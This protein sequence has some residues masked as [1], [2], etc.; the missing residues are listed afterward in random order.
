MR[1]PSRLRRRPAVAGVLWMLSFAPLA[2]CGGG[3]GGGGGGGPVTPPASIAYALAPTTFETGDV[4]APVAPQVTGGAPDTFAVAPSLPAGLVLSP[5][6]GMFSGTP[7]TPTPHGVYTVTA[8]NSA[9]S[10]QTTLDLTVVLARAENLAPKD[11]ATF[12]DDD[13]RYFLGRTH[14][15]TKPSEV[16]AVKAVGIPAYVD[17]MVDA[18]GDT[19]A[20][21]EN[22]AAG[23]LVNATDPVGLEGG[24][25]SQTQVARYWMHLMLNNPQPFQDALA[26]FWHDHF[27]SSTTPIESNATWF[28]VQQVNLWRKQGSGNL[29]SLLL[30]MARDSMML[31][32]LDGILNTKSAPNENFAREWFELFSLGVDNG[33]TQTDIVQAA[34]AFTGY[35]LRF[36]ATTGQ[37]FTQFD[38]SRHDTGAKTVLGVTIPG[39]NVTDDYQAVVDATIDHRPVAEFISKKLF[40]YFC[41]QGPTNVPTDAMAALLRNNAY[42]LKPLLKALFKSEAFYAPKSKAG[43]VK[44]PVEHYV[45]FC[46]TTGL[47]PIDNKAITDPAAWPQNLLRTVDTVL[48]TCAQRPSQP[49]SVNGWPVSEEWLSAQNMLDRVNGVRECIRDRTDQLAANGGVDPARALLSAAPTSLEAVDQLA[50]LLNVKLTDPERTQLANYLDTSYNATTGVVTASPF[51]ANNATHVSERVRG[52]L[53]ILV[54]HPTYAVR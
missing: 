41:Y 27:A 51:D 5:T 49:P 17:A 8:S 25:P 45:G 44:G 14:F 30:A 23:M 32:W 21:L 3:G 34:K 1:R 7:T 47:T 35:R 53:Y 38:T 39:Q 16:A 54:Q 52:L 13:V 18:S 37:A 48:T 15:S 10:A 36:D 26:F 6:T 40:E 12:T 50:L 9:G 22:A 4:L 28:M 43:R 31:V 19:N 20:S 11:P 29:R 42:E 46:R 2:A 33:Y 24:F